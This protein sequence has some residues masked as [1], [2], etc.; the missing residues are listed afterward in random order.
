M[1]WRSHQRKPSQK[2]T[3][4]FAA[5]MAADHGRRALLTVT[6]RYSNLRPSS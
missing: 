1:E 3:T 5:W 6:A 2:T 4:D